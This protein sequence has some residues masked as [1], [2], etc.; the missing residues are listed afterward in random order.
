MRNWCHHY[1]VLQKVGFL[2]LHCQCKQSLSTKPLANTPHSAALAANVA[3]PPKPNEC[4][5]ALGTSIHTW[6]RHH[7]H[8]NQSNEHNHPMISGWPNCAH[9]RPVTPTDP[10]SLATRCSIAFHNSDLSS[11]SAGSSCA[12]TVRNAM[13]SVIEPGL[14]CSLWRDWRTCS[15]EKFVEARAAKLDCWR[16]GEF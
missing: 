16:N 15:A 11:V 5:P 12:T 13:Y 1:L 3:Q 7:H 10:T 14:A 8:S 2:N 4:A 9:M 6:Q